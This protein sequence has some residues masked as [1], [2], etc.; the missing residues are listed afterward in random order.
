MQARAQSCDT[1]ISSLIKNIQAQQVQQFDGEFYPGMF[2][3]FRQCGGAPHNYSRDNNI[4]F[5]SVSAFALRNMLINLKGEDYKLVQ[6]MLAGATFAY[7]YFKNRDNLPYYNFWPTNMVIMP[8]T[9]YFKYLKGV[10][11]QGEDADDSVMILMTNNSNDS[12]KRALKNRMVQ[13]SNGGRAKKKIISTY[14]KYK[15]L[16]AYSTWLGSRMTADFDFG[17]QCNIMYFMYESNLPFTKQDSATIQLLA[18]MVHN[19]EYMKAPVYISPYYVKSSV[20]LYHLTRLMNAYSIPALEQYKAQVIKDVYTL[21]SKC[22]NMMDEII[23]RTCLLRL[24]QA[25]PPLHLSSIKEFERSNQQQYV[26][27]QARAAFSYPSPFKQVFLHWSYINYYFYCPAYNK[28]LWLE[29]LTLLNA[30]NKR[31]NT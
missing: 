21:L 27:F 12:A 15:H 2:L 6:Q 18:A 20:L 29:Y 19:R 26:F 14:K 1:L 16:N 4:F 23:L 28:I 17:V 7:P 9:Y 3:S 25:A 22:K 30:K 13:L 31:A 24:G 8:H 11:G 5:T 10:F